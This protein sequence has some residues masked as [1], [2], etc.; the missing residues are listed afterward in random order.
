MNKYIIFSVVGL[1]VILSAGTALA[2]QGDGVRSMMNKEFRQEQ[3]GAMDEIFAN[4]D[5]S[6]WQSL[7]EEKVIESRNRAEDFASSITEDNFAKMSEA[8][9]LM[10]A[11]DFEGAQAIRDELGIGG[12]GRGMGE[13]K[14]GRFG[15]RYFSSPVIE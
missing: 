9:A 13:H 11:G 15:G 14:M 7:M 2:Y 12:L 1:A 6:A 3:K 5:Y 8:H 4:N 10:Q